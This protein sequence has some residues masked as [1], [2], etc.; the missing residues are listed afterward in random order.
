VAFEEVVARD[1]LSGASMDAVALAAGMSKRTVYAVFGSRDALFDA[2]VADI[3]GQLVRPLSP[4][5]SGAPLRD[6]LRAML[7][8][9]AETAASPRRLTILRA[10]IAE[11]PRQPMPSRAFLHNAANAARA[12]LADEL[13]RA[14]ALG[15]I[16]LDNP[17]EAATLLL[18]M[19]CLNPLDRL[20]DPD[21]PTPTTAAADAR[22]DFALEIF[23]K[24]SSPP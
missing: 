3:G 14:R 1:G 18:D 19:A 21:A 17:R 10:L 4:A 24:G 5:Q 11:A 9:E 2:W 6:R 7:R 15:E 22:L 23:L 16:A 20:L 12:R 8:R 13:A